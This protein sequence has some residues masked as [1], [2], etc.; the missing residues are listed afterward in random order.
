[1]AMR[2]HEAT[3]KCDHLI[4]STLDVKNPRIRRAG[5]GAI[6]MIRDF[7]VRLRRSA[8]AD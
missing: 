7:F 2:L 1:M 5:L 3:S 4:P 6:K 8:A